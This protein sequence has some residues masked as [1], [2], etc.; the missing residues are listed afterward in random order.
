MMF[1]DSHSRLALTLIEIGLTVAGVITALTPLALWASWSETVFY[2]VLAVGCASFLVFMALARMRGQL[3]NDDHAGRDALGLK[4]M[5]D[6]YQDWE[7]LQEDDPNVG[8]K[9]RSIKGDASRELGFM[10]RVTFGLVAAAAAVFLAV[11]A[12]FELFYGA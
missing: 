1:F 8:Q 6:R 2:T 12:M 3:T 7:Q 4:S 10:L 9:Q 11:W 5:R